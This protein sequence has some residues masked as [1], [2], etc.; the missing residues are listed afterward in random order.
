VINCNARD[1]YRRSYQGKKWVPYDLRGKKTRAIRRR[2]TAG[3]KNKRT[4]RQ[5][6][7]EVNFAKRKYALRS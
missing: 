7:R 1:E 5:Y 3:Q 4:L 6:K 2:L